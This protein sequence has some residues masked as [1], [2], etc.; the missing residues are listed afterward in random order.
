MKL[1]KKAKRVFRGVIYDVY[2]W[3]QR[4]YDGSYEKYEGLKR[5]NTV[6]VLATSGRKILIGL[7]EQPSVGKFIGLPGG[8]VDPGETALHAAKREFLEETGYKSEKWQ[9]WG[10]EDFSMTKIEGSIFYFFA[11]DCKKVAE[12]ELEQGERIRV[13]AV[14]WTEFL[15][16]VARP[17]FREREVAL[18]IL[19]LMTDKKKLK[20]FR[21][22]LFGL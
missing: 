13:K 1:P 9:L 18:K 22:E 6:N 10:K 19:R 11:R 5:P 3:Q 12:P 17:G 20:Q 16:I 7:Q 21:Q 14:S 15:R 8:R 4:V 2:H